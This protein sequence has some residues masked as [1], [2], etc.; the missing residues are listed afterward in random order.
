[1]R[2]PEVAAALQVGRRVYLRAPT[3]TDERE[4]LERNRASRALHRGWVAP[5][6]DHGA[7]QQWMRRLDDPWT[8]GY[9]LCRREDGA[10]VGVFVL[11]QIVRRGFQS[12]YL[13]YYG[14]R[15]FDGQ[16]YMTDGMPLL[17]RQVFAGLKL[18]R[19]EANIQPENQAS[20][21]LVKRAGFRL[22]GYSPRYLKI[23]GRWRD[24]ERWAMLVD[25]WQ[26]LRKR[27]RA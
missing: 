8:R 24:H 12:A 1:M 26:R 27:R 5:P 21:A 3:A 10:I 2:N 17:L 15:P 13:G 18:H 25:D 16:G 22:E 19:V 23:A 6:T 20:R 9:L 11:S 14:L 4:I 7:F